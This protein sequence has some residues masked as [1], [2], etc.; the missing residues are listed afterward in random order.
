ML[1]RKYGYIFLVGSLIAGCASGP[2]HETGWS[3][4]NNPHDGLWQDADEV[5]F[6]FVLEQTWGVEEGPEEFLLSRIW[7]IQVDDDG[8]IYILNN[9]AGELSSFNAQGGHRWTVGRIGEGPGEFHRVSSM[10][11]DGS[12]HIFIFNQSGSR[13]DRFTLEGE[14]VDSHATE[15]FGHS[16]LRGVGMLNA[17]T[18][19]AKDSPSGIF[20]IEIVIISMKADWNLVTSYIIDQSGDLDIPAGLSSS[21]DVNVMDGFIVNSHL[22]KYLFE[23]R[24]STGTVHSRVTRDIDK[25]VRP[26]THVNGGLRVIALFGGMNTPIR[27]A[28]TYYVATGFW[29]ADHIDPDERAARLTDRSSPPERVEY[30]STI[31]LYNAQFELLYSWTTP[32]NSHEDFRSIEGWDREGKIYVAMNTDFPQIGRFRVEVTPPRNQT[33]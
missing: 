29:P 21:L 2:V 9:G 20:G 11:Y 31:D 16:S 1:M 32:D 19:V 5:P 26:G 13:I 30:E 12:E 18:I 4:V 7:E 23:F 10:I 8:N 14:Y 24:D 33:R 17:E 3:Q 6:R 25:L 15:R 28:D 22:S 27:L